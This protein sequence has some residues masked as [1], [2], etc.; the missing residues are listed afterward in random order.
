[1]LD[2]A[3]AAAH[4]DDAGMIGADDFNAAASVQIVMDIEAALGVVDRRDFAI[5]AFG[6][7]GSVLGGS[8]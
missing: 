5:G 6:D 8:D 1:M 3:S 2:I 7:G 4:D